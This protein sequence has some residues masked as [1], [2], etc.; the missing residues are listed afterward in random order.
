MH[1]LN[2]KNVL[3]CLEYDRHSKNFPA[4]GL[5]RTDLAATKQSG[6]TVEHTRKTFA[7]SEKL[8]FANRKSK[9]KYASTYVDEAFKAWWLTVG[10]IIEQGSVE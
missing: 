7:L 5:A 8:L 6:R 1:K 10:Q 2:F 4:E 3:T 9:S